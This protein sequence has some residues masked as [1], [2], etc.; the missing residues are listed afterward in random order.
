MDVICRA[1]D[2][3]AGREELINHLALSHVVTLRQ[4]ELA[5]ESITRITV[6]PLNVLRRVHATCVQREDLD[7]SA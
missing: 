1:M 6:L 5:D 3:Q 7:A 2:A 4:L